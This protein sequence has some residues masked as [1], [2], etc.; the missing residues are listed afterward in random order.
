MVA[1]ASLMIRAA[2]QHDVEMLAWS[3]S[4]SVPAF[5][6]IPPA[7]MPNQP[8]ATTVDGAT[9]TNGTR[10]VNHGV[11]TVVAAG[12]LGIDAGGI[13]ENAGTLLLQDQ[14]NISEPTRQA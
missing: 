6:R 2:V 1:P 12:W 13:L 9:I 8:A 4:R 3:C 7:S 14:A 5:S 11:M 10:V